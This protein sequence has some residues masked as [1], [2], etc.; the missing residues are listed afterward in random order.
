MI[1]AARI[2]GLL[3]SPERRRVVAA[4]L[5][6]S[7]RVDEITEASGLEP[8]EA[9]DAPSRLVDAGLVDSGNDG[10]YLLLEEA[11]T[12][13]ARD[14]APPPRPSE[15]PDAPPDAARVLDT[16]FR[17]GRLVNLPTKQSRR[18]IVLDHLAQRFE[19]GVHY[20]E[21]QVNASLSQVSEDT[22]TLRRYL[23]DHGFLDRAGGEYWRSGGTVE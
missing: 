18:L 12:I 9:L 14:A 5:L 3:G 23:V 21:R 7:T 15:H 1:D 4:L 8:R 13:A 11:F 20:T 10:T 19:P 2:I 22:A 6:G 16:A 17:D